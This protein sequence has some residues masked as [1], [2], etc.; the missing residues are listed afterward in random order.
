MK[1]KGVVADEM[2]PEGAGP[3]MDLEEMYKE[4]D[5]QFI[6]ETSTPIRSEI[7]GVGKKPEQS[8]MRKRFKQIAECK[9]Q[10]RRREISK[11][12]IKLSWQR[13]LAEC[14]TLNKP[15]LECAGGSSGLLMDLA[16]NEKSVHADFFNDFEDLFDDE[17]LA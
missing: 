5:G 16:A 14:P 6:E 9:K 17:D 2:F 1:P 3:Y 7:L 12:G 4:I 10:R 11:K 15:R 13:S 8:F